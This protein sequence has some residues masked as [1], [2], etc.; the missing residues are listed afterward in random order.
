MNAASS[1]YETIISSG[2]L[3]SIL[4]SE[5]LVIIDCRFDLVDYSLGFNE[6]RSNHISGAI[7]AHL[8]DDL[9]S[10]ATTTSGRHPLPDMA[11]FQE[12]LGSWGIDNKTQVVIYDQS[13][14]G[15]AGRLWWMLRAM[16]HT[17]VAV[18][19]GGFAKWTAEGLPVEDGVATNPAKNFEGRFQADWVVSVEQIEQTLDSQNL[20]LIDSRDAGRYRG[21]SEPIDAAA[22]HIP[23]ALNRFFGNNLIDSGQLRTADE[24]R[25]ELESLMGDKPIE[26]VVFYCGS[27][28]T[29]C[30]NL[31]AMEHAG[32]SGAKLY[33]GSWSE[34][35]RNPE[36]PFNTGDQP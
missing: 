7:Y 13:S 35:S 18:L 15:Y 23:G 8:N 30:H 5:D 1:Q 2:Q 24:L 4:Q 27:G 14:G 31:L 33:V 9:S 11:E 16:G 19:D 32:L 21:D 36:R 10:E 26:D 3:K 6:Y 22:G 28:V 25:S 29:A 34:W 12:K 20:L 17:A